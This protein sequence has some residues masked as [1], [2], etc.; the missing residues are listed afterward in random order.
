SFC[1][2]LQLEVLHSQVLRLC[3]DR[4]RDFIVVEEYTAGSRL[5]LCYWRLPKFDENNVERENTTCKLCVQM[6]PTDPSKPLQV[7]HVPHLNQK[8]AQLADQAIK[9][10]FLSV[11][12]LLIHTVHIRTKHK[13]QELSE[14]LKPL[15][16]LPECV[17]SGSPAVLHC[18]ILQ[19]CMISEELLITVNT[20]TGHFL[21]HVP[22]FERSIRWL[23]SQSFWEL[24]MK[25]PEFSQTPLVQS[26]SSFGVGSE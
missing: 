20:H 6:D 8:D 15:L 1:Q 5:V 2:S 10:D 24:S 4:L 3:R 22:Q 13:L 14:V 18:P 7:T 26:K 9:S 11:E 16:G 25:S 19:P 23:K 12:K 17:I 21:A